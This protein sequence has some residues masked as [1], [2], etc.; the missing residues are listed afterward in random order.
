[1]AR[2]FAGAGRSP[3]VRRSRRPR[4]VRPYIA[5]SK[6]PSVAPCS[7]S[8]P[9]GWFDARQRQGLD[10]V[11]RRADRAGTGRVLELKELRLHSNDRRRAERGRRGDGDH[12]GSKVHEMVVLK[13]DAAPGSLKVGADRTVSEDTSVGED[14]ET[15]AG[16]TKS[17]TINL[18]PG[19]YILVCNIEGHYQKGMYTAF[20]VS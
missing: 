9:G 2:A 10:S 1:M 3:E 15:A 14:S 13:T 17:T 16:K 12:G 20:T 19:R 5:P 4:V 6:P 18:K 11:R 8:V 7:D